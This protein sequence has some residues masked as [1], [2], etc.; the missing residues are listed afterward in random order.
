VS[1][2]DVHHSLASTVLVE[3]D[4]RFYFY[5]PGLGVIGSAES[6]SVA[7]DKFL[8]LRSSYLDEVRR[9]GLAALPAYSSQVQASAIVSRPNFLKELQLFAA[10][11]AIVLV[12]VGLIGMFVG[13]IVSRALHDVTASVRRVEPISMNDVADKAAAI[14]EDL[15]SMSQERRESLRQSIGVISRELTPFVEA[16]RNPPEAPITPQK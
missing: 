12:I 1:E 16:W 14:V 10:K 11:T 9:A 15:K 2:A 6:I 8:E 3:R 5:Q 7:Y 13:A 4:G